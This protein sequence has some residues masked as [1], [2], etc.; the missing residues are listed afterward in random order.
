MKEGDSGFRTKINISVFVRLRKWHIHSALFACVGLAGR[1]KRQV[2]I[3]FTSLS[4]I[5]ATAF[6]LKVLNAFYVWYVSTILGKCCTWHVTAWGLV[7]PLCTLS[8]HDSSRSAGGSLATNHLLL[9]RLFTMSRV[10]DKGEPG[11]HLERLLIQ[12]K[13]CSRFRLVKLS[14]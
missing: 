7:F 8:R 5:V 12:K 10:S 13:A 6:G 2:H 9:C 11:W 14:G 3:L 4:I 1:R